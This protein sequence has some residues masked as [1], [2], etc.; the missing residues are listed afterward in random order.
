MSKVKITVTESNCR[1]GYC[2]AGDEFIIEDL[3]PPMCHE[4]WNVI[5]PMVYT[6]LNGG[7]LDHG[8]TRAKCFDAK[9]PD[10]GRVSLHAE[11]ID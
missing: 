4:L 5:Y 11:V 10:E 2:R 1:C 9:C 3:C 8:D 7:T 6:L